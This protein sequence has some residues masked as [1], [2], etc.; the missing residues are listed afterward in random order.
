MGYVGAENL[1]KMNKARMVYA[2]AIKTKGE[3]ISG[4]RFGF[5]NP[6]LTK[7]CDFATNYPMCSYLVFKRQSFI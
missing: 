7:V 4:S 1:R 6:H 5:L 3:D 2:P